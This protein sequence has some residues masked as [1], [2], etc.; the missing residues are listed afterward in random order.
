M[1]PVLPDGRSGSL[2]TEQQLAYLIGRKIAEEGIEPGEQL[3]ETMRDLSDDIDER[4]SDAIALDISQSL[5]VLFTTY[6]N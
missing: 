6:F 3:K 2:P 1:K 4:I 5:D